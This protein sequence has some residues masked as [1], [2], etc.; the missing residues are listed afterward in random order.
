MKP[1]ILN[2]VVILMTLL[3]T[4][5]K[6]TLEKTDPG[7]MGRYQRMELLKETRMLALLRS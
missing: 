6:K 5:P 7:L 4:V 2:L 3:S 1:A